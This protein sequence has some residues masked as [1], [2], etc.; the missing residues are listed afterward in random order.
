MTLGKLE[1]DKLK[2]QLRKIDNKL[3]SHP[4]ELMFYR[5]RA[6]KKHFRNIRMQKGCIR[7]MQHAI[8]IILKLYG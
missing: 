2:I 1:L 3:R 7:G 4:S 5:E 8:L 6:Y